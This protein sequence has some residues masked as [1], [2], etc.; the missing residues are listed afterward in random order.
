MSYWS[1][2]LTLQSDI[3]ADTFSIRQRGR[4]SAPPRLV[5]DAISAIA[6]RAQRRSARSE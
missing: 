2:R 3:V 6:F 1:A 5:A 4:K